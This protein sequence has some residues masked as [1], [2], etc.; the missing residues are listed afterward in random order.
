MELKKYQ[1]A[2]LKDLRLFAG[3]YAQVGEVETAHVSYCSKQ[4]LTIGRN[5]DVEA[6]KDTLEGTPRVC[7]KVPTGGGKTFIGVNAVRALFEELPSKVR[8]VVWLVPRREILSQTLRQFRDPS[9]FTRKVLNR[10]FAGRV[11]VLGKEDGLAGQSFNVATVHDQLTVFVLSY[12]SFKNIDGRRAFKENSALAALCAQQR[13]EGTA[14]SVEGAAPDSL[15]SALAGTNPLVIVDESH[16]ATSSLSNDMLKALN[17]R[18]VLELTATPARSANIIT[19]VSARDLK[20]EEMIKLPVIVY[21]RGGKTKVVED[22]V[23]LQRRLERHAIENE[24][25][26]GDYIRPIVLLQAERRTNEEAETFERLKAR[27]VTGCGIPENQIA[28]QTDKVKDLD[29]VDLMSRDCPIRYVITVD[30]LAE[31][32]DCPFAYVLATVANKNSTVSVEQIVGRVLRQPYVHRAAVR[33]LNVSYVLTSSADFDATLDQVVT[34]LNGAGFDEEDV[35]S[36]MSSDRKAADAGDLQMQQETFSGLGDDPETLDDF[37]FHLPSQPSQDPGASELTNNDD[38]EDV[39]QDASRAEEE[40]EAKADAPEPAGDRVGAGMADTRAFGICTP[41][42]EAVRSTRLPMY[43]MLI[44]GSSSLFDFSE[45][46]RF[47]SKMLLDDFNLKQCGVNG[48]HF[49]ASSSEGI[50]AVDLSDTGDDTFKIKRISKEQLRDM[51]ILFDKLPDDEKR[52]AITNRVVEAFSGQF[53]NKYTEPEL[54]DYVRRVVEG[55]SYDQLEAAYDSYPHLAKTIKTAVEDIANEHC[56]KRFDILVGTGR[57]R[58]AADAYEFPESFYQSKPM[59]Q[60]ERTLYEAE[61]GRVDD[62]ERKLIDDLANCPAIVWW[63]RIVERRQG[64]FCINGYVNHYPDFVA[65][66]KTG[67]IILIEAKGSH[68]DGLLSK[69]KLELG[70][71]W[72]D[73]AGDNYQ[74]FMVFDS[75]AIEGANAYSL[76]A[77]RSYVLPN[78]L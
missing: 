7:V 72:A 23:V 71:Q 75:A 38:M 28:I 32:W 5:G 54:R 45:W 27:L 40:F 12:D 43:E 62:L 22:A 77:F 4:G 58:L 67:R 36:G 53:R 31:G 6:Y 15:V 64:E 56:K 17:P 73:K 25:V 70:T 16:H 47:D 21:R 41:V 59:R 44:D 24:Q 11:E 60:Y 33:T 48:I 8:T 42:F 13:A 65:Q 20:R 49:T 51:R 10:D 30:A 14:V 68:L 55:M 3:E 35:V 29:G 66:T 63:H 46:K 26:T 50:R 76:D 61:D 57:I 2:V 1:R 9:H 69:R 39:L 74:Y 18:F 19:Q 34:G 78:L 37:E 52:R